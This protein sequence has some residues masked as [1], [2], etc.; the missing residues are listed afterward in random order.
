MPI[1]SY[2]CR[3]CR[4]IFDLLVGVTADEEEP[5]CVKCGSSD[6]EKLLTSFAVKP[7]GSDSGSCT[8]PT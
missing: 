3:N 4:A 6:L 8:T 7:S 1:Y 2:K 5:R